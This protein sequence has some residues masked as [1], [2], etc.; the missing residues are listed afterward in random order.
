MHYKNCGNFRDAHVEPALQADK[1]VVPPR[2]RDLVV[3]FAAAVQLHPLGGRGQR[4]AGVRGNQRRDRLHQVR[5]GGV[6]A[7][8]GVLAGPGLGLVQRHQGLRRRAL[9]P[10]A[11]AAARLVLQAQE[12]ARANQGAVSGDSVRVL[13]G[14]AVQHEILLQHPQMGGRAK[15]FSAWMNFYCCDESFVSASGKCGNGK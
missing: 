1:G 4:R 6:R 11:A 12:Q 14:G 5:Q 15:G 13:Q 2:L 9:C 7:P 10:R 3:H 8:E